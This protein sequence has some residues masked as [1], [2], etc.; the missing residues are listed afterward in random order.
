M[1]EYMYLSQ[2]V[3]SLE[4]ISLCL[5]DYRSKKILGGLCTIIISSSIRHN[6]GATKLSLS[7]PTSS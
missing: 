5:E 2:N 1:N 3:H 4:E 7:Q 6:R